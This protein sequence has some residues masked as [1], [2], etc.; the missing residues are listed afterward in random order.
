MSRAADRSD[1]P[2]AMIH[3][4]ILDVAAEMPK[5]P[6]EAIGEEVR[7]LDRLLD[8]RSLL[9]VEAVLDRREQVVD[10]GVGVRLATVDGVDPFVEPAPG[11]DLALD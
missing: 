4:R 5:A 3:R 9:S 10:D 8:R 7:V 6:L 1:G 2:R 11:P